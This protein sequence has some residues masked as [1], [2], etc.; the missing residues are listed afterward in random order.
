METT[1]ALRD[2][3]LAVAPSLRTFGLSLCGTVDRAEELVQEA[4]LQAHTHLESFQPGTNLSA[5]LAEQRARLEFSE[6]R[7]AL[8]KLSS[9]QRQAVMLVGASNLS[10]AAAAL[11][12]C[13]AGTIKSRVHRARAIS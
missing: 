6:F 12:G 2:E 5:W 13:A 8:F 9:E 7:A 11:C 1:P 4:F 10:Y 3:L